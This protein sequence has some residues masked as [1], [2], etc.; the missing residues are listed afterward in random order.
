MAKTDWEY[1]YLRNHPLHLEFSRECCA[2]AS[3]AYPAWIG[4][5]ASQLVRNLGSL[6]YSLGKPKRRVFLLEGPGAMAAALLRRAPGC[7]ILMLNADPILINLHLA[8]GPKRWITLYL[9]SKVD[10]FLSPAN[11]MLEASRR[12]FPDKLHRIFHLYVDRDRWRPLPPEKRNED[13]LY[14]GRA[15]RFKNQELT[16]RVFHAVKARHGLDIR[17]NVVGYIAEEYKPVLAPLLDESITF[18]GWRKA[19]WEDLPAC[20]YYFN[21]ALLEPSGTNILEALALG[22]APIVSIG[23]GY[24]NDVVARIDPKL[25]VPFEEEKVIEAWEYLRGLDPEAREAL[26]RKCLEEAARWTRERALGTF[27]DICAECAAGA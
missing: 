15:D 25:I 16:L 18:T 27:R 20:G 9:L 24:A 7:R 23:C 13:F 1:V 10:A 11:L 4:K 19:P 12:H 5:S 14:I 17:M 6:L 22:L 21:L 8:R 26:R 2:H 3:P